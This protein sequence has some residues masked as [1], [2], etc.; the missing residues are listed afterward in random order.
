ML[1]NPVKGYESKDYSSIEVPYS[2]KL[3]KFYKI[4][5]YRNAVT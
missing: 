4:I 5:G 2:A 1:E 3:E